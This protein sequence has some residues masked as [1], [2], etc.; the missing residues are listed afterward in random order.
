MITKITGEQPFQVL[1]NNF[2]ISPSS[3][4][5]TLQISADG[6]NFSNLFT[7]GAGVTRLVTGVAANSYYRLS[8]NASAVSINW[9]K[10]CVTEGGGGDLSNYYTKEET[11]EAIQE[12]IA[13][14]SGGTADLSDYWTSAQTQTAISQATEGMLTSAD[15]V[16]FL[17]SADTANFITSG[18]VKTQVEAY[19][20]LTSA[21]TQD[22]L[23]SADTQDFLTSA[24]TVNFLTSA[25]TADFITETDLLP[26]EQAISEALNDLNE[27]VNTLSGETVD[28]SAYWTSAQTQSAINT[29]TEGML[30]SADTANF[31][32]SGDVKTQIEDYHYLTSADTVDF[33]TSADTV[34][35]LT[36][37]DTANF[38]TSGDVATQISG[39]TG[40]MVVSQQ[41]D[42]IWKG[43][44]AQYDALTNSGATANTRIMYIIS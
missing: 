28:L 29:A 5:Y 9:M 13:E 38:V 43:T 8:G 31:V 2:S 14:I 20:Y 24:D 18:D 39:A 7:V 15:T 30:T 26:K 21:D 3:E 41:I 32:S 12:A 37:A 22:F 4:G 44:Q 35:F 11:D 6:V 33:I 40:D 17:T 25:D 19:G 10:T 23:T 16:N 34:D 36:S 1:T 27:R 42:G